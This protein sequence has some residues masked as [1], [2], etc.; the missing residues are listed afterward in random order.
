ME[1]KRSSSGSAVKGPR[2][3]YGATGKRIFDILLI[4]AL[5]PFVVPFVLASAVLIMMD[6]HNPFYSQQR[7]GKGGSTFRMWKL[8]TMVFNADDMLEAYL[9]ENPVAKLEW[10]STQKL[11]KDPRITLVGRLLRKTSLDELPQLW[12]VFAGTM[13]I[14]GPRP[15]MVSQKDSYSGEG[16]YRLQPGITGLWQVSDRNECEFVGRARYDDMYERL[17]SFRTDL[18]VLMRTVVVV[19]RCTGY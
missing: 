13:S 6:G 8:R 7:I 3:F 18:W 16:Y 12:N 5:A 17:M 4:L 14:V 19:I 11:K 15:M 10:E 1:D 2:G 9:A